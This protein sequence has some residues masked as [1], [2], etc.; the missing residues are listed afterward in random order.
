LHD[1]DPGTNK[2]PYVPF[3]GF[4]EDLTGVPYGLIRS[5]MPLQDEVN[6]RR[7]KLMWLLSSKRVEMDSDSLD[8]RYNDFQTVMDEI[9]RPDSMII[10]NPGRT[11][12]DGIKVE[13]D[14]GLSQQ[15]FE[16]LQDAKAGIQE[17]A[18]I[19]NTVLGKKDGA[20]SSGIAM[21]TLVEQSSN[22]LG[23][24]N[25]NF[26]FA[27]QQVGERLLALIRMDMSGRPVDV[28]AGESEARRKIISLNQPKVDDLTGVQYATNDTDRANVKVA[29]D[30]VPSTPAYRQQQMMQLGETLKSLPPAAQAALIPFFIESTDLPKRHKMADLARK[31]MG[32]PV[33]GQEQDPQV[34][35]LQQQLQALHQQSDQAMQQYEQ[36]VQEKAQE[37]QQ[38]GQTVAQLQLQLRDKGAELQLRQQEIAAKAQADAAT[39]AAKM[40]ELAMKEADQQ[41]AAQRLE[42]DRGQLQIE[43]S[44]RQAEMQRQA[45]D[46]EHAQLSAAAQAE[47]ARQAA[48]RDHKLKLTQHHDSIAT[49]SADAQH[50]A[51]Q[52]EADRQH[53]IQMAQ[54]A[55]EAADRASDKAAAQEAEK[56]EPVEDEGKELKQIQATVEKL[57]A[58]LATQIE[59]I[60]KLVAADAKSDATESKSTKPAKRQ[61]VIQRDANGRMTSASIE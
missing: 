45:S 16:V 39:A 38:L 19:Y 1:Y 41:L 5:M 49:A 48:L 53:Q 37:A 42:L 50:Q 35:M 61:V 47:E 8:Q 54:A 57:L 4:R 34:A 7:R 12:A 29:L 58:P 43:S 10:R 23:E 2:M 6:A 33:D 55:Q 27:R 28:V 31:A 25:D 9:S 17:A 30:D 44:V 59:Q 15:Q 14:L 26:K 51:A 36:A 11:H 32:L 21:N 46:Q 13:S 18:G 22:T 24:I 40:R 60:A 52:A 3:W 56:P 20:A